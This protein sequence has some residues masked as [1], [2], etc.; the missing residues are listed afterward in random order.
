[1]NKL[2]NVNICLVIFT[3]CY[4]PVFIGLYTIRYFCGPIYGIR[5]FDELFGQYRVNLNTSTK[6]YQ[7]KESSD[8]NPIRSSRLDT[9]SFIKGSRNQN[10][11]K[12]S[13]LKEKYKKI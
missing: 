10:V 7:K 8:G 5:I 6:E 9:G 11:R 13:R 12:E 3:L 4:F 2:S 1:M